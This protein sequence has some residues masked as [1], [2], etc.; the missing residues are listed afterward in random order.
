MN[1]VDSREVVVDAESADGEVYALIHRAKQMTL[2]RVEDP[3]TSQIQDALA[4][5]EIRVMKSY[6]P[7]L[8]REGTVAA[9]I[10]SETLDVLDVLSTGPGLDDEGGVFWD[11]C[12][13]VLRSS[14]RSEAPDDRVVC[15]SELRYETL[16]PLTFAILSKMSERLSEYASV[17]LG[18]VKYKCFG[19]G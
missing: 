18:A 3:R 13:A 16:T 17:G 4:R 8:L 2:R 6:R 11:G 19:T 10:R 12:D 9:R 14:Q 1:N 15:G 7:K 5:R